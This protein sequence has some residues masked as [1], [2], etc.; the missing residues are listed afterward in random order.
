L[1][2][3]GV[4]LQDLKGLKPRARGKQSLI[5]CEQNK[6]KQIFKLESV[7]NVIVGCPIAT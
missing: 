1:T 4:E 2:K 7:C 6:D 5:A 3:L